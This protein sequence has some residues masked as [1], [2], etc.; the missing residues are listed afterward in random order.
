MILDEID[1]SLIRE[2]LKDARQPYSELSKHV[3]IANSTTIERIKKLQEKGVINGFSLS[4]DYRKLGYDL[5]AFVQVL[6]NDPK[7]EDSFVSA[8]NDF[9]EVE[10]CHFI[11]GDYSYL[12][13]I[14]TRNSADLE[15]FLKNKLNS[16]AGVIRANT[17]VALS[18][19]KQKGRIEI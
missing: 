5:C 9:H 1:K 19:P 4:L 8:L 10:E 16:L 2:L 13:K 7:N 15:D 11:T 14:R 12:L 18:S 3:G 17:V 6:I